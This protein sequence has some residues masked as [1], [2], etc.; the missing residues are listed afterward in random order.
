MGRVEY[1]LLGAVGA[2]IAFI[3]LKG[4]MPEPPRRTLD[5]VQQAQ[6]AME[7]APLTDVPDPAKN[8]AKPTPR[9][10]DVNNA[11]R[12]T[13]APKLVRNVAEIRRR[14][15]EG[16]RG[17]YMLDM[18]DTQDSVL[19]RWP[20]SRDQPLRVWVQSNPK[21]RNWWIGYVQTARETFMEW[22]TAGLPIRFEYPT[23]STGADI[24]I[25]WIEQFPSNELRIGK[26]RRLADHNAWVT[27]A[28][29]V[30][31]LHDREGDSF[32]P[33]EVN[34]IL[35]HEIGHAL[36]LGH[37]KDRET[38]MYPENTQLEITSMDKETLRLLYTLP[39]GSIKR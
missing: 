33:D 30:V 11:V 32:P 13:G 3:V 29:I 39:P 15:S 35:R 4:V 28:E 21:I 10:T 24:V 5:F 20:D 7:D 6:P 8:A 9:A 22:E 18:L 36:G 26:T 16:S 23:D 38:I 27:R 17:T 37:S 25:R 14:I 34:E 1:W 2:L 31:A 19:Y 12:R